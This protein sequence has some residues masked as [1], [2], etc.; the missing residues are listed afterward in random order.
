MAGSG[1]EGL[2]ERDAGGWADAGFHAAAEERQADGVVGRPGQLH[3]DAAEDALAEFEHDAIAGDA[4]FEAALA[5]AETLGVAMIQSCVVMQ[6]AGVE[7]RAITVETT[8]GFAANLLR[9][10][11]RHGQSAVKPRR[12]G[13]AL[14]EVA[15]FAGREPSETSFELVLSIGH[16]GAGEPG[17]DALSS[18]FAFGDRL[19]H[20]FVRPHRV[21]GSEHA[22]AAGHPR[23]GVDANATGGRLNV[24]CV[25]PR[26]VRPA[27]GEQHSVEVF[28]KVVEGV[29]IVDGHAS[30]TFR[31]Q[32][33]RRVGLGQ[34]D[35]P[36]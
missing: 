10:Q 6:P 17:V 11:F 27:G 34:Q 28:G 15:E 3:T 26:G 2:V 16:V 32:R 19:H 5:V 22:R 35:L 9:G 25:Q 36:R 23:M 30:A 24:G 14:T 4:T 18:Q 21:A 13:R 20:E 8:L 7:G 29:G 1:A 31:T 33:E 12:I